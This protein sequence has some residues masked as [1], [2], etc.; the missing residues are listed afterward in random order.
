MKF[1]SG[2]PMPISHAFKWFCFQFFFSS[3]VVFGIVGF[4]TAGFWLIGL[5]PQVSP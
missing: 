1:K 2:R 4:L 3:L 5:I